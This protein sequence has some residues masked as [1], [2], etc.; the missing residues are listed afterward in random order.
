MLEEDQT[1]WE[2]DIESEMLTPD[3]IHTDEHT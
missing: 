3:P 2:L 1:E